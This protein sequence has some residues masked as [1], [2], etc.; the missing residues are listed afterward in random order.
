MTTQKNK[1]KEYM[2][3]KDLEKV[4]DTCTLDLHQIDEVWPNLYIGNV[5]IA[6]NRTAL[7][8]LGITH[9]LNAAHSKR[10]SIGD[11]NFY[12]TNFVYCGI[13]AEDSCHF[14]LDIYFRPAADFIHKGLKAPDGKVLVHCIMGMSRSS[15]LV[16]AY[17]MLYHQMPLRS[18]VQRVVKKR[19]IYPNRN[20]LA[21]LLDLDLQ[22]KRKR[23]TCVLL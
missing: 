17:L 7:Q 18:A 10:G 4:L 3:V 12:G 11:Q 8:Q 14:D 2:C 15:T 1:R 5:R 16:L 13:P 23:K 20:F 21:L 19:A 6:Q 22:M 9:I